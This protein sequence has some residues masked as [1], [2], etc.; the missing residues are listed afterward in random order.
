M[1]VNYRTTKEASEHLPG[2]VFPEREAAWAGENTLEVG[3][4]GELKT[5]QVELGGETTGLSDTYWDSGEKEKES[6]YPVLTRVSR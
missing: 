1:V 6:L 4:L 5:F 3:E 2:R